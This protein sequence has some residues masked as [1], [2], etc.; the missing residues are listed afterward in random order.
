MVLRGAACAQLRFVI[1]FGYDRQ[2]AGVT[3]DRFGK[4]LGMLT[5]LGR[6]SSFRRW[7]ASQCQQLRFLNIHEYQVRDALAISQ[8]YVDTFVMACLQCRHARWLHCRAPR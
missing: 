3:A 5:S 8:P 6:S 1:R 7:A 4:V 2:I